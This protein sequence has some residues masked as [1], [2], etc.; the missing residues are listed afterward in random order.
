M[1]KLS[2]LPQGLRTTAFS[3]GGLVAAVL[4]FALAKEFGVI[5]ASLA[6]RVV[7]M[8]FGVILIVTGNVL[9][10]VV[11]PL[12][13]RNRADA[14]ANDRFAGR[15]FVLAGILYLAV[16][17]LAPKENAML[18]SSVIGFGGFVI[19]FATWA[20]KAITALSRNQ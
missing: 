15:I 1:N 16:W 14:M 11:Q 8:I 13:A 2:P 3:I 19:I 5:D 4:A 20:L 6:K 17:V 10:K 12:N 18:V 9:P 7:G